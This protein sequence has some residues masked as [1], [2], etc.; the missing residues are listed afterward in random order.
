MRKRTDSKGKIYSV[1]ASTNIS[2]RK[3]EEIRRDGRVQFEFKKSV[4]VN[5]GIKRLRKNW[6]RQR[7][8]FIF[9]FLAVIRTETR[10]VNGDLI[11]VIFQKM[12]YVIVTSTSYL[13]A[14][15]VAD[16]MIR[17]VKRIAEKE[18]GK[19]NVIGVY[20]SQVDVGEASAEKFDINK[21]SVQVDGS[22]KKLLRMIT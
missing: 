6:F 18:Y 7:R 5:F 11:E 20:L 22:S 1:R 4:E 3:R 14:S 16:R 17:R 12:Y 10:D 13:W 19:G 8:K 2:K 21:I 9:Y 15:R